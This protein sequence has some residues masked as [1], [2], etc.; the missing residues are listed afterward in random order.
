M[1]RKAAATTATARCRRQWLQ[2][3]LRHGGVFATAARALSS[4]AEQEEAVA[5]TQ[6]M[7]GKYGPGTYRLFRALYKDLA[8]EMRREAGAR[9]PPPV[10]G[11][12]VRHDAATNLAVFE[13]AADAAARTGRVVAY[14]PIEVANPPR[15]NALLYFLDWFPVEV[16]VSRNGVVVHFSMA[17]NE[18]GMH[19]RNVRA[20]RET[21]Q[22]LATT[23]DATWV[24]RHLHYD[25]PCLWHLELDVQ[26]ELYDV[27]QDHGVT[28]DWMRWAAGWVYY[29]EHVAYL[30]WSVGVLE[31]LIPS[32][33]RGGEEDFLTPEEK[34]ELERPVEEWLA[35]LDA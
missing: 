8:D 26:N 30:R 16:L 6:A 24:R 28:L 34:E 23:D 20:Y 12:T 10:D 35:G 27:M 13:R 19:M 2:L 11:W 25:G 14:S 15:L 32:A 31:Q 4:G 17:A 1:W 21:A 5:W 3:P 18:G 7:E 29:L 22:L 33:Q 9:P